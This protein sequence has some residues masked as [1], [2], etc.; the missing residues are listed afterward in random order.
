MKRKAVLLIAAVVC[1]CLAAC[2]EQSQESH[3][4][5]TPV[6]TEQTIVPETEE[7]IVFGETVEGLT[8]G[9]DVTPPDEMPEQP[10]ADYTLP[11][12][13]TLQGEFY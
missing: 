4:E 2:S 1:V 13:E 8:P 10:E 9:D 11:P 3:P 6:H 5:Q 7:T 12:E